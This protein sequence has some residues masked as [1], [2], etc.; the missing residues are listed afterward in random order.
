VRKPICG[1]FE[2]QL[3]RERNQPLPGIADKAAEAHRLALAQTGIEIKRRPEPFKL[4]G[5]GQVNL[6]AITLGNQLFYPVDRSKV[7]IF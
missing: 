4:D 3:R 2:E 7:L 1:A 5:E 6:I